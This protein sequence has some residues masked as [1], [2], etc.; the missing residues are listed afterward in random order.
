MSIKMRVLYS[1]SKAKIR[2][3]VGLIKS[4]YDLG[5][6][7]VDVIPPA[8]SCDKERAVVLIISASGKLQNKDIL[9]LKEMTKLRSANT[10][11]VI[12]GDQNAANA[13]KALLSE[14]GTNVFDE[15]LFIKGG[16]P[17]LK[18]YKPEEKDALLAWVS[19]F[20]NQLK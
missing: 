4:E 19:R 15:V 9:F 2:S 16:I 14:A 3:F 18:G 6:N 17:F 11:L 1:S 7:S 5:V 12:D 10:A 13:A 8:Y 20:V